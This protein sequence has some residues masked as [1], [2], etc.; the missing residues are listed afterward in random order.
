MKTN[1]GLLIL[2][3]SVVFIVLASGCTQQL[4][5]KGQAEKGSN[6]STLSLGSLCSGEAECAY[7]C[8]SNMGR[9]ISYCEQNKN[10]ALCEIV[11]QSQT[12]IQPQQNNQTGTT[13][14]IEP[15]KETCTSN[16]NPTFTAAFTDN[17]K[18]LNIFPVGNLPFG[19]PGTQVRTYINMKQEN[20][21]VLVPVYAPIN[22]TLK[23]ITYSNRTLR[24]QMVRAEYRLD[25]QVSCEVTYAFD[26]LAAIADRF[27][28]V[29][30]ATPANNTGTGAMVSIPVTAGELVGYTDRNF[31]NGNWDFFVLN[32]AHNETFINPSR[33]TSDHS[34]HG[35][36][37]YDYYTD[38]LKSEYYSL[39]LKSRDSD[40]PSCRTV[41]RDIPGTLS[42]GWFQ[43]NSTE[44][45]GSRLAVASFA[46]M[47]DLEIVRDNQPRFFIRDANAGVVKPEKVTAGN[48][49]CYY[50][51]EQNI[52]IFLRLLSDT[53]ISL[54]TGV[55]EC[56][57]TPPAAN[58]AW[59]R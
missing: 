39:L 44:V 2:V 53:E 7:F 42:G 6:T 19:N 20:S 36:C 40:K 57:L 52:H 3:V 22:S 25:F 46:D 4:A 21:T 45:Q 26:H 58:E 32:T 30:P 59:I 31:I 49:V 10:N 12:S 1:T 15:I 13:L 34:K 27:K 47:V 8:L 9:C 54:A 33:W 51:R 23:K 56:P 43:G 38:N 48:T 17:S 29:S 55:R 50:D 24:D 28:G 14:K 18:I 5:G 35:V 16:P 41:S 11:I 37:P